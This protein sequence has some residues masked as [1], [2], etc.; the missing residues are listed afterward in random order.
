VM[1]DMKAAGPR[2]AFLILAFL[3]LAFFT[4]SSI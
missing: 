3:I 2:L 4:P 1:T